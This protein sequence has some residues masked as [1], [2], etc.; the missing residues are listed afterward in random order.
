MRSAAIFLFATLSIALVGSAAASGD[1]RY[2][3]EME[4]W[5]DGEQRG[6]PLVVLPPGEQGSVEVRNEEGD[7]GWKIEVL[8][9]AP[10]AT[11]SAPLGSTWLN[12]AVHELQDGEW[13]LLADSLLGVPEGRSTSMSVVGS[14]VEQATRENS[15]VHLSARA[16]L[17]RPGERQP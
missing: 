4:L 6:T 13:N 15:R 3:V 7:Q 16:S 14:E 1:D 10:A 11:Q 12:L 5:I 9:E 2:M 17:M 8:V